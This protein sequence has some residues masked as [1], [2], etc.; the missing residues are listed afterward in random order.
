MSRERLTAEK[1]EKEDPIQ[2]ALSALTKAIGAADEKVEEKV[3]E[4]VAAD[5]NEKAN[6][7][8]PLT[9]AERN[10]V[11]SALIKLAKSM[12]DEEPTKKQVS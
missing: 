7:N 5:Q 10:K 4:K 1:E 6:K 2:A 12:L 9:D 3:E 8:W 11:A